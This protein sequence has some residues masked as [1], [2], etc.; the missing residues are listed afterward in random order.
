[1][2]G[3]TKAMAGANTKVVGIPIEEQLTKTNNRTVVLLGN[4]FQKPSLSLAASPVVDIYEYAFRRAGILNDYERGIIEDSL[5]CNQLLAAYKLAWIL[6]D[7]IKNNQVGE[8]LDA[9]TIDKWLHSL[10]R[11]DCDRIKGIVNGVL[12][13]ILL[14]FPQG[15]GLWNTIN[16][17]AKNLSG[18]QNNYIAIIAVLNAAIGAFNKELEFS[19]VNRRYS[20]DDLNTAESELRKA[21]YVALTQAMI[22]KIYNMPGFN[23]QILVETYLYVNDFKSALNSIPIR[24]FSSDYGSSL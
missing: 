20:K 9:K 24:K 16:D 7:K 10:E 17:Q 3:I 14:M 13:M 19:K 23:R 21:L 12:G 4:N 2:S 1:M 22:V 18:I 15:S 11:D 6:K 5:Y 8:D